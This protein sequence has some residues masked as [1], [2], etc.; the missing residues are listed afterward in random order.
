MFSLFNVAQLAVRGERASPVGRAHLMSHSLF[1]FS[2]GDQQNMSSTHRLLPQT[3][4][5]AYQR[6]CG[7][8]LTFGGK[9]CLF[10]VTSHS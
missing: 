1:F 9:I 5:V 10:D 4:Y 3:K 2:E 8:M 6:G 7:A